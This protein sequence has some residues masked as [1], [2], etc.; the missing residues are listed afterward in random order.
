MTGQ[1]S[2]SFIKKD[3]D[4]ANQVTKSSRINCVPNS[5]SKL[6]DLGQYFTTK[7]SN[8]SERNSV[9]IRY[10]F[11]DGLLCSIPQTLKSYSYIYIY[12]QK[13]GFFRYQNEIFVCCF[14][15]LQRQSKA[16]KDVFNKK[17]EYSIT[18]QYSPKSHTILILV[19]NFRKQFKVSFEQQILE[20]L[21]MPIS[22][23][24][25]SFCQKS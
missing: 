15:A 8:K 9:V 14:E 10:I 19:V 23:Y 1:S 6:Y 13:L 20:K 5:L 22:F 17:Q 25:Q 24:S 7:M 18:L 3:Y 16:S 21:Y 2:I 11:R 12:R 4:L